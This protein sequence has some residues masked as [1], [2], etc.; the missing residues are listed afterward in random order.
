MALRT[1][2]PGQSNCAVRPSRKS[3]KGSQLICASAKTPMM[4]RYGAYAATTEPPSSPVRGPRWV[5]STSSTA[6]PAMTGTPAPPISSPGCQ[7][8][9]KATSAPADNSDATMSVS[10]TEM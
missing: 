2:R 3:L 4:I 10:S 9:R 5:R 7:M 8:R 6:P 1:C